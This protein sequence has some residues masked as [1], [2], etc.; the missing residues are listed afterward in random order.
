MK[1]L[2]TAQQVLPVTLFFC[3]LFTGCGSSRPSTLI[4]SIRS[5]QSLEEVK[6]SLKLG[7]KQ[8]KVYSDYKAI[9]ALT[10]SVP[11]Y[12]HRGVSGELHL[13]FFEDQLMSTS[14]YSASADYKSYKMSL[15]RELGVPIN[16]EIDVKVNGTAIHLAEWI[17]RDGIT[18]VNI[19]LN[20]EFSE[21]A[22]IN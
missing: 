10:I 16:K 19:P 9:H 7:S 12:V 2:T 20:D 3:L 4:N 1:S 15:K 11:N 8:W 18:W 5:H 21:W 13:R 22:W 6:R 14:F 17:G